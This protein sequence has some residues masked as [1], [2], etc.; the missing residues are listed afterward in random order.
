MEALTTAIEKVAVSNEGT[1]NT[2][3]EEDTAGPS[4]NALK[5]AQKE[6]EKRR[7][8]EEKAAK[9]AAEGSKK[10]AEDAVDTSEGFYGNLPLIQS[11]TRT[12]NI[13]SVA[14][15]WQARN[16]V[17]LLESVLLSM[18]PMSL[19]VLECIISDFKVSLRTTVLTLYRV[20]NGVFGIASAD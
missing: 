16:V 15:N 19:C 18:E 9:Q 12:G 7:K 8:K 5:K 20:Q 4:K 10:E 17:E 14:I 11:T 2:M 1:A 13:H 6:E 3:T